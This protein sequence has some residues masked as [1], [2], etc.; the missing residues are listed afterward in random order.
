MK[1]MPGSIIG[2]VSR[3]S[4]LIDFEATIVRKRHPWI[5]VTSNASDPEKW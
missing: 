2:E 5:W 1:V 3:I 4:D